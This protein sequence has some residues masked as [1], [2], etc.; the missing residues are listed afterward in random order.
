MADIATQIAFVS[1]CRQIRRVR[2]I[3]DLYILPPVDKYSVLDF[4]CDQEI[5]QIGLEYGR[6]VITNW[7]ESLPTDERGRL[8]WLSQASQFKNKN[9][10]NP[11]YRTRDLSGS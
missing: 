9:K 3:A 6:E 11:I 5:R 8:S 1:A 2:G 7:L 10:T 4:Q